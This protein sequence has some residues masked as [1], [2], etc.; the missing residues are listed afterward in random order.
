MRTATLRIATARPA[1]VVRARRPLLVQN[2]SLWSLQPE[3]KWCYKNPDAAKKLCLVD[4][5]EAIGKKRMCSVGTY[6]DHLGDSDEII[7]LEHGGIHVVFE[8]E[9]TAVPLDSPSKLFVTDVDST[10]AVMVDG[11]KLER[12]KRTQLKPGAVLTC[13]DDVCFQVL[14]NVFAHA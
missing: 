8:A 13:G 6:E 7:K 11:Q 3:P 12:G 5:T 1:T 4:L 10:I 14:R 2:H 9:G